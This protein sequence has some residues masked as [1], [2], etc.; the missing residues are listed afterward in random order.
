MRLAITTTCTRALPV[1]QSWVAHHRRMGVSHFYVFLDDASELAAHQALWLAGVDFIPSDG[2][3]GQQW[4]QH[5]AWPLFGQYVNSQ[6]YARQGLNTALAI[7]RARAKGFDWLIHIDL[8]ELMVLAEGL[9]SLQELLA[10]HRSQDAVHFHNHEAV[11][12]AWHVENYFQEVSLFKKSPFLLTPAQQALAQRS[13]GDQ[14]FLAYLNGKSA[15]NLRRQGRAGEGPH[16]FANCPAYARAEEAWVLHYT[17]CGFNWFAEKY[18]LLARSTSRWLDVE[19]DSQ[20][21]F[22]TAARAA[23]ASGSI[24]ALTRLYQQRLIEQ[25]GLPQRLP[26]LLESGLLFRSHLPRLKQL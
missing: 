22:M 11:P 4:R 6:Y 12:E 14:Y 8:D 2:E 1:L 19:H 18:Q 5:S 24:H 20:L 21:P 7:D 10:A 25:G 15:L 13:F 3:L 9:G 26:S 17:H 23:S 16:S